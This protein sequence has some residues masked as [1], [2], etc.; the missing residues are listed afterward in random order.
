MADFKTSHRGL[1]KI[2]H[3]GW[4]LGTLG[5]TVNNTT[6][7]QLKFSGQERASQIKWPWQLARWKIVIKHIIADGKHSVIKIHQKKLR[8]HQMQCMVLLCF[9]VQLSVLMSVLYLVNTHWGRVQPQSH[10][11]MNSA[12]PPWSKPTLWCNTRVSN[13]WSKESAFISPGLNWTSYEL[14]SNVRN[15]LNIGNFWFNII[16]NFI[17]DWESESVCW[18]SVY[19]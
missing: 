16:K 7:L 12:G 11:C 2:M 8:E 9:P 3:A 14:S 4:K 10:Q 17:K 18:C 19:Q 6:C 15:T 5:K 1:S 13:I